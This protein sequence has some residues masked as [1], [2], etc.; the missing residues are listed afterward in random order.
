[1]NVIP[2]I[3]VALTKYTDF[4]VKCS[5]FLSD[6]EENWNLSA[7]FSE[8]R[9]YQISWKSF[10]LLSSYEYRRTD[11]QNNLNRHCAVCERHWNC[12]IQNWVMAT[13]LVTSSVRNIFRLCF[14][15]EECFCETKRGDQKGASSPFCVRFTHF[16]QKNTWKLQ[17]RYQLS[18]IFCFSDW[19]NFQ[20]AR[21]H[22]HFTLLF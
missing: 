10:E 16:V 15:Y 1:M 11:G 12:L 7:N 22:L 20:A 17:I 21:F 5:L 14:V 19:N 9:E 4:L 3:H 2:L 13:H 8:C 6:N 18:L